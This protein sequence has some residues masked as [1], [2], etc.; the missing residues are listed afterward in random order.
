MRGELDWVLYSLL[1]LLEG[2]GCLANLQRPTVPVLVHDGEHHGDVLHVLPGQLRDEG[3][4]VE[5]VVGV[6]DGLGPEGGDGGGWPPPQGS[7]LSVDTDADP[8]VT[9]GSIV[10]TWVKQHF[11]GMCML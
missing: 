2:D 4:A 3:L 11:E 9:V 7:P 1:G 5:G 8:G 10:A 6:A